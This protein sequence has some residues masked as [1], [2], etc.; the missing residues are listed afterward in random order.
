MQLHHLSHVHIVS[1]SAALALSNDFNTCTVL[2]EA[3][4]RIRSMLP[5]LAAD[6]VCPVQGVVVLLR[7]LLWE[8]GCAQ[9][10]D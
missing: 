10:G 6:E 3:G 2:Q 7:P 5:A 1:S 4:M 9:C 8:A